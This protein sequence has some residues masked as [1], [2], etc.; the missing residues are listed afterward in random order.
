MDMTQSE[1]QRVLLSET[2]QQL[3][4]DI[5]GT[6]RQL[7]M[8]DRRLGVPVD[9]M[10]MLP[11]RASAVRNVLAGSIVVSHATAITALGATFLLGVG[12]GLYLARRATR[13]QA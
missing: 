10:A 8:I 13:N 12:V 9:H 5:A 4:A 11:E 6:H 7:D 1:A 2:A 3:L